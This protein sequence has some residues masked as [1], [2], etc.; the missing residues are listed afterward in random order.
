MT[1]PDFL[2]R[3]WEQTFSPDSGSTKA[4]VAKMW[5]QGHQGKNQSLSLLRTLIPYP[6]CRCKDLQCSYLV[7]GQRNES[8]HISV[9]WFFFF[10]A[11][12]V[13]FLYNKPLNQSSKVW[14]FLR[15]TFSHFVLSWSELSYCAFLNLSNLGNWQWGDLGKL[16]LHSVLLFTCCSVSVC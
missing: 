2:L 15:L 11:G 12:N 10:F 3:F 7:S 13:D 1:T 5:V 9:G 14:Q 16:V 6:A 4:A 8:C